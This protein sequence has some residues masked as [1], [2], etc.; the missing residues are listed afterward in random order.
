MTMEYYP[1]GCGNSPIHSTQ[2]RCPLRKSYYFS[3]FSYG[4]T[5]SSLVGGFF[6][7]VCVCAFNLFHLL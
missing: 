1:V 6:F 2:C 3:H 4:L 7:C 5:L